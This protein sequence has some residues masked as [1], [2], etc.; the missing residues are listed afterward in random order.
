LRLIILLFLILLWVPAESFELKVE[1]GVCFDK[2]LKEQIE[3]ES[4]SVCR[5][6]DCFKA[7][8]DLLESLG[9]EVEE[10]KGKLLV[11][12][13]QKIEEVIVENPVPA[14]EETLKAVKVMLTGR[15]LNDRLIKS[16]VKMVELRLK[17]VGYSRASVKAE[18]IKRGCGYFVKLKLELGEQSKIEKVELICPSGFRKNFEKETEKLT[19]KPLDVELLEKIREKLEN[20]LIEKGYYNGEVKISIIPIRRKKFSILRWKP[21][22]ILIK[23]EPGKRYLIKFS[24]N[25]SFKDKKLHELLTF[26]K[27]RSVDEFEIE[28]S[29]REIEKFYRNNGFPFVKVKVKEVNKENTVELVFIINE[30]PKVIVKQVSISGFKEDEDIKDLKKLIINRP[31]SLEKI[32]ELLNLIKA[33]LKKNGFLN[34]EISYSVSGSSVKI[35]VKKGKQSILTGIEVTGDK[36]LCF[37][38]SHFKLPVIYKPEV[39]Q[40]ISGLLADCYGTKGYPDVKIDIKEEKKELPDRVEVLLRINVNPGKQYR[41]G[42]VVVRGLKRTDIKWIKNLF[43]LQPGEIYSKEKV[44]NQYSRLTDSRLFS[45]ITVRDVKSASCINEVIE[46]SE[47]PYLS[48]RG[49][50]GYG[51][52]SGIVSNGFISS[53]SPFGLGMK[54]FLFGNYRQK[55]GYDAVFKAMK[56]AFPKRHY[57]TS[58]SIVKKEQIFESFKTDKT[59]YT[60]SLKRKASKN[61]TQ[62]FQFQ[63]SREKVKD[64]NIK[65]E[66]H[67]LKR[68]VNLIQTYDR[69]DSSTNPRKGWLAELKFSVAGFLLGGN[70]DFYK[71]EEK[72]LYLVPLTEKRTIAVRLHGGVVQKIGNRGVPIQDRF[73]LGGAE[74][75]RGYKYGTISPT[76]EKGNFI[77]GEAYG[78]VSL[79]LRQDIR[80][81]L[82]LAVFYD[83]GN[84]FRRPQEF[85]LGGWYSSV[86]MGIRYLTPVGPLRL[87]YG[88]KLKSVPGQGRGRVHISFGFPF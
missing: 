18:K 64:T 8:E 33:K 83:S 5:F 48:V 30:G 70:T 22:K 24:G 44:L 63:V 43:F 4:E 23:V 1:E 17:A 38:K 73:F 45:S 67:F 80:K 58:Y 19:G 49:F 31:F 9:Y 32:T 20:T 25:K 82:Q 88:Y 15:K 59:L 84:V 42:Y 3:K 65:T 75:V 54:F 6:S 10:E 66:R 52:D 41:F 72:F 13:Y 2:S 61:F 40:E 39:K 76:D 57:D 87:D 46:L 69:R 28:N 60:F 35:A 62:E 56:P 55:E 79:E 86:G 27:N 7:A 34:P 53:S 26:K 11:K 21:V 12:D 71:L 16:A 78:L 47:G 68:N 37:K 51:T 29:R 77:G 85:K 50:L 14:I 74:S 36:E 81:N